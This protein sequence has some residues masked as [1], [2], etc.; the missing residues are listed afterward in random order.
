MYHTTFLFL[1]ALYH[2]LNVV[3]HLW[4]C[5]WLPFAKNFTFDV[6]HHKLCLPDSTI[7]MLFSTVY[8]AADIQG[9]RASSL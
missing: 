6:K 9:L 5:F 1:K 7:F 8:F 3:K 2:I 4:Q